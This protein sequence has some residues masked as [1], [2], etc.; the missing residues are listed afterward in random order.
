[1][2]QNDGTKV[3]NLLYVQCSAYL[4]VQLTGNFCVV[5]I[6]HMEPGSRM[7]FSMLSQFFAVEVCD[8]LYFYFGPGTFP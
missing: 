8:E 5:L 1:M 2:S 4:L 7:P 6:G 3:I